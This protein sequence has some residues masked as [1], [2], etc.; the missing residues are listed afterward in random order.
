MTGVADFL[1]AVA[2]LI[3]AE[4]RTLRRSV[5]RVMMGFLLVLVG[6]TFLAAGVGLL[7]W[8]VYLLFLEAAGPTLAAFLSG[9][10]TLIAAG[11]LVG[12]AIL[13]NK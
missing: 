2:N 9:I 13:L 6:V 10:F 4:G 8:C 3:E 5:M 7:T 12:V 1:I 11:I